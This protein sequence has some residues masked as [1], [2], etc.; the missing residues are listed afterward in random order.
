MDVI[1]QGLCR[2]KAKTTQEEALSMADS[3]HEWRKDSAGQRLGGTAVEI[4]Y[5][6]P[7]TR[8]FQNSL[9]SNQCSDRL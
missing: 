2:V 8:C 7:G 1:S 3:Q 5:Q 6:R 9:K 4:K